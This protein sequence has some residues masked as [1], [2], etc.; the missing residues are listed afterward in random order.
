VKETT[1]ANYSRWHDVKK[2]R[3]GPDAE[4]RAGVEHAV[5]VA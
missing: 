1:M 4:T 3:T 2:R 5:Q